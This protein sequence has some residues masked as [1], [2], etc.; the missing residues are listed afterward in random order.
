MAKVNQ[1]CQNLRGRSSR[2]SFSKNPKHHL[3]HRQSNSPRRSQ[4]CLNCRTADLLR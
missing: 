2:A 3:S 4:E 1:P